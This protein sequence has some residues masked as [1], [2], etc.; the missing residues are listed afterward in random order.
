MASN[1]LKI[2]LRNTAVPEP[3][4]EPVLRETRREKETPEERPRP[5]QKVNKDKPSTGIPFLHQVTLLL[6]SSLTAAS[7][8]VP[9]FLSGISTSL[10]SHQFYLNW[11]MIKGQLPYNQVFSRAGI[12][13]NSFAALVNYI[14]SDRLMLPIQLVCLYLSG[15]YLYKLI[16][17]LTQDQAIGLGVTSVFYFFN[18]TL[19]FGG[20]YP[21]QLALPFVLMG[22]WILVTYL[23]DWRRDEIFIS[24]GLAAGLAI[25][26]D[27]RTLLFWLLAF[28]VLTISNL[29]KGRLGRGF[30]QNLA[31]LFGLL[32]I[33]LPLGYLG[34]TLGIINDYIWQA[35]SD[36]FLTLTQID[37]SKLM[38][39]GILGLAVVFSGLLT[40]LVFLPK[41]FG[42]MA[43]Q[44]ASLTL[45]SL[46]VL[47]YLITGILS[48]ELVAANFLYLLPFGLILTSCHMGQGQASTSSSRSR[49][50]Q[51]SQLESPKGF[52]R[53]HLFLPAL[54]GLAS[55]AWQA[56]PLISQQEVLIERQQIGQHLNGITTKEDQIYV[57]DSS[58]DIYLI[59]QRL[60]ASQLPLPTV[61]NNQQLIVDQL[62]QD[63]ASYII[64]NK[65]LP[66]PT[67]VKE[68]LESHYEFIAFDE[69]QHFD[70]YQQQ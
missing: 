14:D 48:Q 16:A 31:G 4:P 11:A 26:L 70:I 5:S 20:F 29:A 58:A 39:M 68:R 47:I 10:Q 38:L 28:V 3:K 44:R 2:P 61:Y 49:R 65:S 57:W 18:L 40:G 67:Q 8:L 46:T 36:N 9:I 62:L 60:A 17:Y 12:L 51:P 54:V 30:Y 24:Y 35:L 6:L 37:S 45:L 50:Q 25:S 33:I 55:L 34:I 43:E 41:T 22:L 27:P 66:L 1:S 21:I 64:V 23:D 69:L 59:S 15:R 7:S 13:Y 42:K 19:A 63:K 56:Y 32:V 53:R 52:L